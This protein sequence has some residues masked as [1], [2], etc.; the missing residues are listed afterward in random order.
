LWQGPW[1]QLR[2]TSIIKT[3]H[4]KPTEKLPRIYRDHHGQI[5]CLKSVRIPE[6]PWPMFLCANPAR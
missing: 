3:L 6:Y 1:G 4:Y 5:I 2:K